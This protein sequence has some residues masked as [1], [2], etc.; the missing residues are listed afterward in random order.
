MLPFFTYTTPTYEVWRCK[1]HLHELVGVHVGGHVGAGLAVEVVHS[2]AVRRQL[3]VYVLRD[4]GKLPPA[5]G[6]P[7]EIALAHLRQGLPVSRNSKHVSFASM[8]S[9]TFGNCCRPLASQSP[10]PT[11]SGRPLVALAHLQQGSRVSR[12]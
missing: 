9:S 6:L 12:L 3:R 5:V 11:P 7:E 2:G 8:S 10:P 1:C 4:F